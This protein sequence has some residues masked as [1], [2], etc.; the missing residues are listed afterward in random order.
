MSKGIMESRCLSAWETFLRALMVAILVFG[1]GCGGDTKPPPQ[2][3]EDGAGLCAHPVNRA[4]VPRLEAAGFV[5]AQGPALELCRRMT[6]D[7]VGRL[8]A[9][10]ELDA[11]ASENAGAMADRL[12]AL[13]EYDAYQRR[14]WARRLGLDTSYTVWWQNDHMD[15]LVGRLVAGELGYDEFAGTALTH[16]AFFVPA[17]LQGDYES[18]MY[19]VFLGR[20]ARADEIMALRPLVAGTLT[21]RQV[22]DGRA[23]EIQYQACLEEEAEGERDPD[24]EPCQRNCFG[25]AHEGLANECGCPILEDPEEYGQPVFGCAGTAFGTTVDL[26]FSECEEEDFESRRIFR[27][28]MDRTAGDRNVCEGIGTDCRDLELVYDEDGERFEPA[29]PL[30]E[31]TELVWDRLGVVGDALVSRAD[32]W[33]A[34]VDAE[35]QTLLGW[36]QTSL[37]QPDT[38]LPAIRAVLTEHL[39]TTKSVRSLQRLVVTSLLYTMPSEGLAAAA[40]VEIDPLTA[41]AWS[42]GPSKFLSGERWLDAAQAAVGDSLWGACD[43]RFASGDPWLSYEKSVLVGEVEETDPS[44]D[45]DWAYE[46][47]GEDSE[48]LDQFEEFLYERAAYHVLGAEMGGCKPTPAPPLANLAIVSSQAR[49]STAL[50]ALGRRASPPGLEA[51]DT[52]PAALAAIA[53]YQ[54]RRFLTASPDGE[55]A[56]ILAEDMAACV[57][58]G[59]CGDALVAARWSCARVL[60]STSFAIY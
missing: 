16:P 49:A 39:R 38:D 12:M 34:A 29:L 46:T 37:R 25:E 18:R 21:V 55:V 13:P 14:I 50:C 58:D 4:L 11:C 9:E 44:F 26:G 22:C 40:G 31:A 52:S 20:P 7:L 53:A 6:L 27:R 60:D 15:R 30:G 8:P 28:L 59:A 56:T 43:R 5:P 33:E 41:P 45:L 32:F 2:T 3:C 24:D 23:T 1:L 10:S 47:L 35:L 51:A 54:A 36:W 48:E 57:A 17:K 42:A 19:E